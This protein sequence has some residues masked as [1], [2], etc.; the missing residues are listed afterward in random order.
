[1]RTSPL[2]SPIE[3]WRGTPATLLPSTLPLLLRLPVF[4]KDRVLPLALLLPLMAAMEG[5]GLRRRMLL[6]PESGSDPMLYRAWPDVP[7]SPPMLLPRLKL[8]ACGCQ[9]IALQHA[10]TMQPGQ[11]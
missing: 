5:R 7:D 11:K 10:L 2:P 1:M 3:G 8:W 4:R 9:T 6:P